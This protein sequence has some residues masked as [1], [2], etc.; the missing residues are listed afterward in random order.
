[1]SCNYIKYYRLCSHSWTIYIPEPPL[2]E[3]CF[4]KFYNYFPY[5]AMRHIFRALKRFQGERFHD[6]YGWIMSLYYLLTLLGMS[7]FSWQTGVLH[8][9]FEFGSICYFVRLFPCDFLLFGLRS[10]SF[11]LQA[12]SIF[13]G[14]IWPA[15]CNSNE[16]VKPRIH[17]LEVYGGGLAN[18]GR[19]TT[20]VTWC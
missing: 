19:S 7:K 3:H 5:L 20:D 18:S 6:C 17:N 13:R 4:S 12:R 16:L 14:I 8:W 9:I 2:I 15:Y 10:R 1:M 11:P